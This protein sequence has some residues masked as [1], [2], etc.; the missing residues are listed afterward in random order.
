MDPMQE[1]NQKSQILHAVF[2]PIRR[3]AVIE[4]VF[5]TLSNLPQT[6]YERLRYKT[7]TQKT[8][9]PPKGQSETNSRIQYFA[10]EAKPQEANPR[11]KSKAKPRAKPSPKQTGW[12]KAKKA[13]HR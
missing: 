6:R 13:E 8:C 1:K 3:Q 5:E 7:Q 2:E 11:P 9:D 10:P 4:A 12:H